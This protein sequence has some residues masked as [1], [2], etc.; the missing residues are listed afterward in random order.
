MNL[1]CIKCSMFTKNNDIKRK[2]LF[3][4]KISKKQ[5]SCKK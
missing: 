1:Y 4:G 5:K 2:C 3:D